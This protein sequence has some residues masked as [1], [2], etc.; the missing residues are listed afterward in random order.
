MKGSLEAR[1]VIQERKKRYTIII[2]ADR[3]RARIFLRRYKRLVEFKDLIADH[4]AAHEAGT[5]KPGR[6]Q[7]RAAM[8]RHAIEP[9]TDPDQKQEKDFAVQVAHTLKETTESYDTKE[10]IL[11][12][13]PE[14][15]GFLRKELAEDIYGKVKREISKDLTKSSLKELESYLDV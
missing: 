10:I 12:A 8:A 5:S 11:I 4:R 15:L 9:R 6:V 1:R 3:G 7:E 14:F 13:P 2:I